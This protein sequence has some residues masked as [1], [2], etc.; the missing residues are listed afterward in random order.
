MK[1]YSLI[2]FYRDNVGCSCQHCGRGIKNIAVIRDNLTGEKLVVGTTCVDKLLGINEKANKLLQKRIKEYTRMKDRYTKEIEYKNNLNEYIETRLIENAQYDLD[3]Y[4]Y[5]KPWEVV[6]DSIH[7][8]EFAYNQLLIHTKEFNK[9]SKTKLVD[10]IILDELLE[11]QENFK[12]RFKTVKKGNNWEY[13]L[14]NEPEIQ[15]LL[16][17]YN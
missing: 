1:A 12:N 14:S 9:L 11:G 16:N 5:K 2:D 10:L 6:R 8:I 4:N 3:D 17:I 13:D 15:K 7:T